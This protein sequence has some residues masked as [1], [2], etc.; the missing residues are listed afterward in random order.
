[1]SNP[2]KSKQPIKEYNGFWWIPGDNQNQF[3]GNLKID[4]NGE[5]YLQLFGNTLEEREEYL[6][7]NFNILYGV[8]EDDIEITI[9]NRYRSKGLASSFFSLKSEYRYC[10]IGYHAS[11]ENEISFKEIHVNI[12]EMFGWFTNYEIQLIHQKKDRFYIED[13]LYTDNERKISI[14]AVNEE[15]WKSSGRNIIMQR[16]GYFKFV[17]ENPKTYYDFFEEMKGISMLFSILSRDKILIQ[18]ILIPYMKSNIPKKALLYIN[19][20]TYFRPIV[21]RNFKS[22]LGREILVSSIDKVFKKLYELDESDKFILEVLSDKYLRTPGNARSE[23]FNIVSAFE[24]WHRHNISEIDEENV[25]IYDKIILELGNKKDLVDFVGS[26]SILFKGVSFP[27]RIKFLI[28]K[29]RWGLIKNDKVFTKIVVSTRNMIAHNLKKSKYVANFGE[30]IVVQNIIHSILELEFLKS[31]S[32]N[33]KFINIHM[34]NHPIIE[35]TVLQ[36]TSNG[37]MI[38]FYKN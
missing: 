22:K 18:E 32:L 7:L 4:E 6:E 2:I 9:F 35:R 11:I 33:D 31:F 13:E 14:C 5:I 20:Q 34:Q 27:K 38:R 26:R 37:E 23:F 15:T 3:Y 12:S 28:C 16:K 19:N 36:I 21:E 29:D 24:S 17:Y 30:L 10:L 8:C 25:K 1:M